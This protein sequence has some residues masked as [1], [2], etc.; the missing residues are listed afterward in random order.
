M[1]NRMMWITALITGMLAPSGPAAEPPLAER[2]LHEGKLA[3]GE[4]SLKET[5]AKTPK[6][7]QARFGLGVVQFV[8][9]IE[10]LGQSFHR[11]GLTTTRWRQIAFLRLPVPENP[12]P[13]TMT[14]EVSRKILQDFID[15]LTKAE[16]TLAEIEDEKVRLPIR[17]GMIQLNLTGTGGNREEFRRILNQYFAAGQNRLKEDLRIVFDRGDV[18]WFRGYCHLLMGIAEFTLAHDGQELFECTAHLFFQ[19]VQTPHEFLK[20]PDDGPEGI[21][22]LKAFE[23]VDIISLIHL[24]RMPVKE[25]ARMKS[26]LAHF[27]QML[28]LS[29]ETW[30]FI[31]AETDDDHEWLPNPKQAGV[32]RIPITQDMID[33]WLEFV[34]ESEALLAGKRLVPFWRGNGEQGINLRRVFTEPKSFDLV[35]WIQGTAATPYLEKGTLTKPEVWRQLQQTFAGD[36][37]GFAIWF[38]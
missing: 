32:M 30:K 28:A 27:E 29:K 31:L 11:Y 19:K 17:V 7:D 6:D 26:S 10:K 36:F 3:E 25:P 14:Y 23:I 18:A 38:N 16:K 9:A 1:F 12:K 13:D 21:G 5:L 22:G 4:A 2:F 24:I 37:I 15:D 35:L 20:K 8:G 34:D 33:R